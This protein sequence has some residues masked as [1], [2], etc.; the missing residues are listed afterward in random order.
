MFEKI[1]EGFARSIEMVT[2][3]LSKALNDAISHMVIKDNYIIKNK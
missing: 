1:E 3:N 2:S